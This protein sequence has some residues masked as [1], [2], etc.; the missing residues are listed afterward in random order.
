MS[1]GGARRRRLPGVEGDPFHIEALEPRLLLSGTP[2][3][4]AAGLP[5]GGR[6]YVNEVIASFATTEE[7]DSFSITV[8][9]GQRLSARLSPMDGSIVAQLE[10]VNDA[11]EVVLSSAVA[12]GPGQQVILEP[13]LLDDATTQTYTLNVRN[14]AGAGVYQLSVLL[15]GQFESELPG[16]SMN[17]T[18]EQAELLAG[19]FTPL[20]DD[21]G[22]LVV[23]GEVNG[24]ADVYAFELAAGESVTLALTSDN[25]E[26]FHST[27]FGTFSGARQAV[28][29]D[30][31]GDGRA[32]L[33]IAHSFSSGGSLRVHLNQGDG[34]F[35]A[36]TMYD[37]GNQLQGLALVDLNDDGHLDVVAVD[38]SPFYDG[39]TT[40]PVSVLLGNGDGTFGERTTY[41]TGASAAH[42]MAVADVNNDGVMDLLVTYESS[43]DGRLSVLLGNGDG[44]FATALVSNVGRGPRQIAT[45][46]VDGDGMVDVVVARQSN[47]AS[48]GGAVTTTSHQTNDDA[49]GVALL[50]GRGD[51]TFEDPVAIDT[52]HTSPTA[53]LLHDF[54]GDGRLDLVV[55]SQGQGEVPDAVGGVSLLLGGGD[56]TF[57]PPAD[58]AFG[59]TEPYALTAGDVNGDGFV[60]LIVGSEGNGSAGGGTAVLLSDGLGN[61]HQAERWFDDITGMGAA[62]GDINGDGRTDIVA[63]TASSVFSST[64]SVHLI[65]QIGV[66]ALSL[67]DDTGA[68]LTL[69][70]HEPLLHQ[71]GQLIRRFTAET[72]GTYHARIGDGHGAYALLVT[73]NAD[74]AA[75]ANDT[76]DTAQPITPGVPIIGRYDPDSSIT[77]TTTFTKVLVDGEGFRWDVWR[78]GRITSGT[79]SAFDW[80]G[81]LHGFPSLTTGL[82]E[83]G[84][85]EIV[86]GAATVSQNVTGGNG[87]V[88]VIRKIYISETDGFARYL[89]IVTNTANTAAQF[90]YTIES[91]LGT[92]GASQGT[93][94]SSGDDTFDTSD[95]WV[96]SDTGAY[97]EPA[98]T[99]VIGGPDGALQ[100]T[101]ANLDGAATTWSYLLDLAPGETKIVAHFLAQS[102][103]FD[104][105][106]DKAQRLAALP[107]EALR[108]LS[109]AER[110][111]IVNFAVTGGDE[112]H[113][114]FTAAAGDVLTITTQTPGDG[115]GEPTNSFNPAL[116]LYYDDGDTLIPVAVDQDSGDGHNA[117]LQ[118]VVPAGQGGVYRVVLTAE[119]GSGA[120]DYTLLVEGATPAAAPFTADAASVVDGGA[121]AAFPHTYRVTFSEPVL[122]TSLQASDLTVN[123]IAATS[124]TVLDARTVVFNIADADMGPGA[125]NV[126][127]AGG[128]V[129]SITGEPLQAFN[130]SFTV[131]VQPPTVV[132]QSIS[133]GEVISAEPWTYTATFSE[134]LDA[135]HLDRHDVTVTRQ[136]T[137]ET[138][139]ASTVH[140]DPAT[141]TLTAEF[142]ALAEGQYT[143]RL[144]S[145]ATSLR[146]RAGHTIDGNADTVAGDDVTVTFSVD[147]EEVAM[148][149]TFAAV[150]PAVANLARADWQGVFHVS[151]D[152]DTFTLD[153][154][155]GERLTALFTSIDVILGRIELIGPGDTVLD[156]S[157]ASTPGESLIATAAISESGVYRLRVTSIEGTGAYHITAARNATVEAEGGAV[158]GNDTAESAQNIDASIITIDGVDR[159]AVLGQL[160]G[161]G[162][163]YSFTLEDGETVSIALTSPEGRVASDD[164]LS[165]TTRL[166]LDSDD[167]W[168]LRPH[169][170]DVDGDGYDDLVISDL[171]QGGIWVLRNDGAG[172]F[173]DIER[174]DTATWAER[175]H[176]ADITGDGVVDIVATI[177]FHGF[178]LLIGN[179]DG[180]FTSPIVVHAPDVTSNVAIA[181]LVGDALPDFVYAGDD[182]IVVMENLGD[183]SFG[184]AVRLVD[185]YA[186]FV[187]VVHLDDDEHADLLF[188]GGFDSQVHT[189]LNNGMGGFHDVVAHDLGVEYRA[190]FDATPTLADFTGDDIADLVLIDQS[191]RALLVLQGQGDGTFADP[192]IH[193]VNGFIEAVQAADVDGD[194]VLDLLV[195]LYAEEASLVW[196]AGRGDG[197]FADARIIAA[198]TSDNA[199][200]TGDFNGDGLLD[201]TS[202]GYSSAGGIFVQQ[203]RRD[204]TLRL[205]DSD[206]RLL[207]QG[208]AG[209]EQFDQIITNYLATNSGTYFI[210]VT[211]DARDYSIVVAHNATFDI[212]GTGA[213]ITGQEIPADT[214]VLGHF[215]GNDDAGRP[216]LI[217]DSYNIAYLFDAYGYMW[218]I[219]GGGSIVYGSNR[220]F[221]YGGMYNWDAWYFNA[222]QSEDGDR[223]FL[224]GPSPYGSI[225]LN[226]KVYVP[227]DGGFARILEIYTNTGDTPTSHTVRIESD[228]REMLIY[229]TSSGDTVFSTADEWI[230]ATQWGDRPAVGIVTAGAGAMHPS[231]VAANNDTLRHEYTLN[232][233]PGET[234]I[235]MHFAVQDVDPAA[236]QARLMALAALQAGA[237]AGMSPAERDAVINFNID[238]SDS[239][240][241]TVTDAT[242]LAINTTPTA[243]S[244]LQMQVR[245]Y[246]LDGDNPDTPVAIA[247]DP[248]D[249]LLQYDVSG[250]ALGRYRVVVERIDGSGNYTL[251][252]DTSEP[253]TVAPASAFH[254]S[255][256]T[257]PD[258]A[259]LVAYP[260]QYTLQFSEQVLLSSVD[261]G[262]LL[263]NGI[264]AANVTVLDGN[265][266]IFDISPALAGDGLYELTIAP[267]AITSVSGRS[268][269]G[270]TAS[271]TADVTSP[272]VIESSISDGDVL[273]AAPFIYTARFSE[274]LATTNLGIED[275]ELRNVL[276]NETVAPLSFDY[277]ETTQT[278]TVA[279]DT[280]GDG[281][282]ALRLRS[283]DDAFRDLLDKPLDGAPAFPLPSGDGA[284]G[285]D[286]VVR[287]SVDSTSEAVTALAP[288]GPHGSLMFGR[289]LVRS[290]HTTGDT[291]AFTLALDAGQLLTVRVTPLDPSVQAQLTI[292]NN[293][294][295]VFT[296]AAA[297]SGQS[298]FIQSL[299]I[300]TAG[301]YTID[302]SALAGT[303]GYELQLL[304]NAV[305]EPGDHGGETNNDIASA[306]AL[307]LSSV[308]LF[309][310]FDR[311][312]AVGR[313]GFGHDFYRFSLTAGQVADIVLTAPDAI[314]LAL[315]DGE[316]NVIVFGTVGGVDTRSTIE[317][318]IAI[319]TGD[320]YLRVTGNSITQGD[321]YQLLITRGG[322]FERE[323][324]DHVG[325]APDLLLTDNGNGEQV[326]H[327]VGSVYVPPPIG[328][329]V[330]PNAAGEDFI[331]LRAMMDAVDLTGSFNISTFQS[332]GRTI[333]RLTQQ[334]TGRT[335]ETD[336]R[337][338]LYRIHAG[339]GDT[340]TATL[341][342]LT[343]NI[344]SIQLYDNQGFFLV[345]GGSGSN[346]RSIANFNDFPY[347]GDYYI[348]IRNSFGENDYELTIDRLDTPNPLFL[349]GHDVYR[350]DAHA[351]DTLDLRTV[352]PGDGPHLPQNVLDARIEL[353]NAQGDILA[354]DSNSLDG[355]NPHLIHTVDA[356]GPYFV[357][358][359]AENNTTGEYALRVARTGEPITSGDSPQVV[360]VLPNLNNAVA[361]K[362]TY[363][364][365]TFDQVIRRDTISAANLVFDN[366][367]VTV[368]GVQMIN[369]NT[370]RFELDVTGEDGVYHWT[371]T[372][373]AVSNLANQ[374][375]EVHTGQFEIDLTHPYIVGVVPSTQAAA[376]FN[377]VTFIFSEEMDEDFLRTFHY[378]VLAPDGANVSIQSVSLANG[379]EVTITFAP[380]T[381]EGIYT[382]TARSSIRD[383]AGNLLDQD[384]DGVG[385]EFEE[386]DFV[387]Q[388]N[389]QSPNLAVTNV[390]APDNA[391]FGQTIALTYTVAN[392]GSDAAIEGWQDRIY[393]STDTNRDAS[394][395]LLATVPAD[396]TFGPLAGAGN[397]NDSYTRTVF[398][399]LPV[400]TSLTSG[401]YYLIV[402]TDAGQTQ[403]E[404]VENDNARASGP[405][406]ITQLQQPDL[407]VTNAVVPPLLLAG[408]AATV[409]WTIRNTGLDTAT[410][411]WVDRIYL[412]SDN[413]LN[414][415]DTL[416]ASI[417][418]N[419]ALDPGIDVERQH[420]ITLPSNI[421]GNY[422]L[423]IVTDATDTIVEPNGENNNVIAVSIT[424]FSPAG[425]H[426]V[427]SQ[428]ATDAPLNAPPAFIDFT[429]NQPI[430]A[431]SL[432]V[433]DLAFDNPA[434]Q[435]LGVS[436]I[437][438]TTA[439]FALSVP[440]GEST[441]SYQLL[442]D[443]VTD[444]L[445]QT[446]TAFDGTL[447]IDQTGP[448]V[449]G[450]T[451]STQVVAPFSSVR[452]TFNEAMNP[453]SLAPINFRVAAPDGTPLA[454][455]AVNIISEQEIELRFT[456]WSI[457]GAYTITVLSAVTDL[458]GNP[459]NQD[460]DA[461]PGEPGDDNFTATLVLQSPNLAV[462]NIDAP[463]EGQFGQTITLTYTVTNLGP[464]AAVEGWRDRIYLSNNATLS[465]NDI[466]LHTTDATI[467]HLDGQSGNNSYSRTVTLQLP[468]DVN[469]EPG[470]YHLIVQTDALGTQPET[471]ESDNLGSVAISIIA[472]IAP[473]LQVTQVTAPA[474]AT[475]GE[476]LTLHWTLAN[477]GAGAA[478]GTWT[479][480]IYLAL[481]PN[482][483]GELIAEVTFTGTIEAGATVERQHTINLPRPLEGTYYFR[484]ETDVHNVVDEYIHENNNTGSSSAVEVVMPP[485][486]DLVVTAVTSPAS[487][488]SHSAITVTWTVLNQGPADATGVWR[489]RVL[490]SSDTQFGGDRLLGDFIFDGVIEA[491]QSIT[492]SQIVNL[493]FD[494]SGDWFI[495]VQADAENDVE[496]HHGEH[497]N[498]FVSS[499][500]VHITTLPH[501]NLQGANVTTP[502]T[503][504]ELGRSITVSWEAFNAGN[505]ATS[506]NFWWD[507]VY[508]SVDTVLDS[509]DIRL[510]EAR[511]VSALNPGESYGN[512]AAVTING[513]AEGLYYLLV[514]IDDD[515]RVEE[516]NNEG[517][518]VIVGPQ[519]QVTP[520]PP[521]DLVVTEVNAPTQAF[522]GQPVQVTYRVQNIGPGQPF[523]NWRDEVYI[524]LDEHLD[525]NDIRVGQFQRSTFD[526]LGSDPLDYTVTVNVVPPYSV[527]GEYYF[528]V[529]TDATNTVN[530]FAFEHNNSNHDSTPTLIHLTPP[531]DLELTIDNAPAVV[532]AGRTFTI[533]YTVTNF[534]ATRT[535]N[536]RWNDAVYLSSDGVFNPLEDTRLSLQPVNRPFQ[537]LHDQTVLPGGLG[538]G[539]SYSRTVTLKTDVDLEG[540]YTLFIVA[541][542]DDVVFEL[543][544]AN[545]LIALEVT[546]VAN[547]PD[548]VVSDITGDAA[549]QSGKPMTIDY[550]VT[551][552]GGGD[553][554][555]ASWTDRLYMSLNDVI[556]DD[557]D[558]LIASRQHQGALDPNDSYS[559]SF[560]FATPFDVT[561]DVRFYVRT[562]TSNV[563]YETDETNN[564]STLH[565]VAVTRITADLAA[566]VQSLATDLGRIHIAWQVENLGDTVTNAQWWNDRIIFSTN[567]ILGDDDD[568]IVANVFH[569]GALSPT[570]SYT[571]SR[572]FNPPHHL[573][574]VYHV[575][576]HV[577][578]GNAVDE[579][580]SENNNVVLA[581]TVDIAALRSNPNLVVHDVDAPLD[582]VS[583]QAFELTYIVRNIGDLFPDQGPFPPEFGNGTWVDRIYL[584]RDQVFDAHSDIYLGQVSVT[585]TDL[586]TVDDNGITYQE[587]TRTESFTVPAGLTGPFYVFVITDRNNNIVEDATMPTGES[588]NIAYDLTAMIV[589]LAPPADLIAGHVT[590]PPN[591]S[592]GGSLIVTYLLTNI[593]E[594][595]IHG[596]W[597]DR[598]FL[599]RDQVLSPDD[600]LLSSHTRTNP[601]GLEPGDSISAIASG[602]VTNVAPGDY[603]IIVRTDAFDAIPESDET[604]NLAASIQ[605]V[606]IDAPRIEIIDGEGRVYLDQVIPHRSVVTLYYRIDVE[607]GKTLR[608]DANILPFD[609]FDPFNPPDWS[610]DVSASL[611]IAHERVPGP[612]DYDYAQQ[613]WMYAFD[614]FSNT[615]PLI[616]PQT[617]EGVYLLRL[618]IQDTHL[619]GIPRYN[620]YI[621]YEIIVEE[622]PFTIVSATPQ[623]VGNVGEVTLELIL[624]NVNLCTHAELLHNGQVVRTARII[625]PLDATRALI[626]FDTTGL[627]AGEYELR[628]QD[629]HGKSASQTITIAQGVGPN[630]QGT[631]TGPAAVRERQEYV[632]YVNYG[633][634]G[635]TNGIAPLLVITNNDNNPF[636]LTRNELYA[637]D[638]A[639]NRVI[640]L[641]GISREGAAD[642]L[643]PGE[644]RSIPIFA[645]VDGGVGDY[646]LQVITADDTRPLI[647]EEI[648]DALRPDAMSDEQ[649]NA[650]RPQLQAMIGDTWG[651]YVRALA[652]TADRMAEMDLATGDVRLIV[653]T[654]VQLARFDQP[655]AMSGHLISA[656]DCLPITEGHVTLIHS[657]TGQ[658]Y[659]AAVNSRGR[660]A[661]RGVPA[662]TY[663]L[664]AEGEGH[665]RTIVEAVV[666][667]DDEP[668]SLNIQMATE[669]RITGTIHF[670][671]TGPA[672]GELIAWA[673]HR[674]RPN[675]SA[676]QY[677]LQLDGN[678]FRFIGMEAGIY[679][680]TFTRAGYL[681]VN[682]TVAVEAGQT[683]DLGDV[684]MDA[685]AGVSGFIDT[686]AL[687]NAA[688]P[689]YISAYQN[690]EHVATVLADDNGSFLFEDLVPGDYT[691]LINPVSAP[692]SETYDVSLDAGQNVT[693]VFLR[694]L[695]GATLRGQLTDTNGTPLA[696]VF[697][698]AIDANRAVYRAL[699]DAN[700]MYQFDELAHGVYQI[701]IAG[702]TSAEMISVNVDALEGDLFAADLV[703]DAAARVDGRI[704]DA[705]GN[706]LRGVAVQ[707]V[708]DGEVIATSQTEANG[709]YAFLLRESGTF[710]IVAAIDG[711]SFTPLRNVTA[712][713]GNNAMPDLVAGTG[714]IELHLEND[715]SAAAGHVVF[716]YHVVDDALLMVG[717]AMADDAGHV[718]F[719]QLVEGDYRIEVLANSTG[720][721]ASLTVHLVDGQATHEDISLVQLHTLSGVVTAPSTPQ[722]VIGAVV[723]LISR[724]DPLRHYQT[725]TDTEGNYNFAGIAQDDY[726]MVIVAD[727]LTAVVHHNVAMTGDAQLDVQL[728]A[729]TNSISGQVRDADG[730]AVVTGQVLALDAD[731]RV[732]GIGQIE[733]DGSFT[734]AGVP[735]GAIRVRFTA[736]GFRSVT[737]DVLT[738]G[739]NDH[740]V[741]GTLTTNA[742]ATGQKHGDAYIP[743]LDDVEAKLQ[744]AEAGLNKLMTTLAV[745]LGLPSWLVDV[746]FNDPEHRDDHVNAADIPDSS[747]PE[748]QSAKFEAVAAS[749][750]QLLTF[751]KFEQAHKKLET[752]ATIVKGLF[753]SE[754]AVVA[755]TAATVVITVRA[756]I[757]L[758]RSAVTAAKAA[759]GFM[760]TLKAIKAGASATAAIEVS[761][762]FHILHLLGV[763]GNGL[764]QLP[765]DIE[766]IFESESAGDAAVNTG[767]AA[768]TVGDV[769]DSAEALANLIFKGAKDLKLM[770]KLGL[771][772]GLLPPLQTIISSFRMEKTSEAIDYY[773]ELEA[774][775]AAAEAAYFAA[776]DAAN[777]KLQ[778][779]R[780]CLDQHDCPED[781]ADANGNGFGDD[782]DGDGALPPVPPDN[783]DGPDDTFKP[784]FIASLDPNDI[785]G[786]AGFGDDNFVPA[787]VDLPYMIRFENVAEATAAAQRVVITH[788]LDADLDYRTFRVDDFG[789]GDLRVELP[790]DAPFYQGRITLS[791]N[792]A[793]AVDVT[794]VVN[795]ATGLV[796]WTMQT[797]DAITGDIPL[798]PFAGFLPPNDEEHRGEGFVT[799]T[800]RPRSDAPT[801]A[802]IDAEAT[803]VFDDNEPIDTPA[804]FNTLDAVAPTSAVDP[805]PAV[806]HTAD[807]TVAVELTWSG[808][809]DDHGSALAS[810]DV[811]VSVD[812]GAFTRLLERTT[813]TSTTY[814]GQV[815]HTYAFYSIAR[816]N[817]GNTE[818]PPET[819]DAIV[820]IEPI[821][822]APTVV[823][824]SVQNGMTQR[825]Y[826]D[827]LRFVFDSA[828]NLGDLITSGAI[829]D[830]VTLTHLGVDATTD[831]AT[832]VS[833]AADQF[834]YDAAT[835][836]LTWS[837][838]SFAGTAASLSDGL[839]AITLHADLI[840]SAAGELD[841]NADATPGDDFV[842]H[843]H[844]LA[845][846]V[847]G[848]MVI[849]AADQALVDSQLGK[850]DTDPDWNPEADTDR[851]GTITTRDRATVARALG[852]QLTPPPVAE[853]SEVVTGPIV[854]TTPEP[855]DTP[856][857]TV[858]LLSPG[859]K[860]MNRPTTTLKLIYAAE[861][862][863]RY[864]EM[865]YHRPAASTP[866]LGAI[867]RNILMARTDTGDDADEGDASGRIK[868]VRSSQ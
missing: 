624:S 438:D 768:L 661:L 377:K 539:E 47:T 158:N 162:D 249:L 507:R 294:G 761:T 745:Q 534:G 421:V 422:Y 202:S 647:F 562:D 141:R 660:Y 571:A 709:D 606:T 281:D 380:R 251:A 486:P 737:S 746:Y 696:S 633:N 306:V 44:T 60:D 522:S 115:E 310:G 788:Q 750:E 669:A 200:A 187:H 392:L 663:R 199:F 297:T 280:L 550:T 703:F 841:G 145:G 483:G 192:L 798:D 818:A 613:N 657:E 362:P 33:L 371:L 424:A 525:E 122:L 602:T 670:D 69:A 592:L 747:C 491:G 184:E 263:V 394:D 313:A 836:T 565:T 96:V 596:T 262:D 441:Y 785:I 301:Q 820:T 398:V 224:F 803:I 741:A 840:A 839:Y 100:P 452:I 49:G 609:P 749:I 342:R 191:S 570:Q 639:D 502:V 161:D 17:D 594:N 409:T 700:G 793:L 168:S 333:Y 14:L 166:L 576:I 641:L 253:N 373:G 223:E 481:E 728:T 446:S 572:T 353:L 243:T 102:N 273:P 175:L 307:D 461:T 492:R 611:Y 193:E 597:T 358:I 630:V 20:M 95:W 490:L 714:S 68:V 74:L 524:S 4:L 838:D 335:S 848:D 844:V 116:A 295:I 790:G 436:L 209:G 226:R 12:D 859:G 629:H 526:F 379:N 179:G 725:T 610:R 244:N 21:A 656:D 101:Q 319:T 651:S 648:E 2:I 556:G 284:G 697:I 833:L 468:V 575:F 690:G 652:Y 595:T 464:D 829:V 508:L 137:G 789:W 772:T 338:D 108:G 850:R 599:S 635:D 619:E 390:A 378:Q 210:E 801:G 649:W 354:A 3:T 713:A 78:T 143:L 742:L 636:A 554:I 15:N 581:G 603:Y 796:T 708:V 695:P 653:I 743:A 545:N 332:N 447:V 849:D 154:E 147:A 276:T 665:A 560:T 6:A 279:F 163:V 401:T 837:L 55:A 428:P 343:G 628:I 666:I 758:V 617:E 817:A 347:A 642:V 393:L 330:E 583:G 494:V 94:T 236:A 472:P 405:V 130:A 604:N 559:G 386:D 54:D 756:L 806:I 797:V 787:D 722:G 512:S 586:I 673:Q 91:W 762:P 631:L 348:A 813:L 256:T 679:D 312:A 573:D 105:A 411:P 692:Y 493:P 510:G 546:V 56:G 258:N 434:V 402:E 440:D 707:L 626:T 266:L 489:D 177:A 426:V 66:P 196:F 487:S 607:A 81:E 110:R 26:A 861:S 269:Q 156:L 90:Q 680:I 34:T 668:L 133:E 385:G 169:V 811:Y 144:H 634:D 24:D 150:G 783:N 612:F 320:Y 252:I 735:T 233:A 802:R 124:M 520:P 234:Q 568:V 329:D 517:D 621:E 685:A 465:S 691:L 854:D 435:V 563:V 615:Q 324:N 241:F 819:P 240:V 22:H 654:M 831:P 136:D 830:A 616:L 711:A 339:P 384:R 687:N 165:F 71:D 70:E 516:Y 415:G 323:A 131:D 672:T 521:P 504:V 278:L 336:D 361:F 828:M 364:Q 219:D 119:A 30:V 104:A 566:T 164:R 532:E 126:A 58:L 19:S 356:D 557:D 84:G 578:T 479:E 399:T 416:L 1:A 121:T 842:F 417:P 235:V 800:I 671:P 57:T 114:T 208:V 810:F 331:S 217:R 763:L 433:T 776:V 113:F 752:Q 755:G 529:V 73:R 64:V 59:F 860:A 655:L 357:R 292:A 291:D 543:D 775:R 16:A 352:T 694:A 555:R 868:L 340:L 188:G 389:L 388:I 454:I 259:N 128:A 203:Q 406:L 180:T 228:L 815:G 530:E 781:D 541:D 497:N 11:G 211:G 403:P 710:D 48:G 809:D 246:H 605:S 72:A 867:A 29:E 765:G 804:I 699:T 852:A 808:G 396:G 32:D 383:G 471:S 451:P 855:E 727:D 39:V 245:L 13:T 744:K 780:E 544:N 412:S 469:L 792:D 782:D 484:V 770:D 359:V 705:Q 43:S 363:L 553:T 499:L 170:A 638:A 83:D 579:A 218:D 823:D 753:A 807:D 268:I 549:A 523:M 302:V 640:Q 425:P 863:A 598:V 506:P 176:F 37:I 80:A 328:A 231:S 50:R 123:G 410:G 229:A 853:T 97:G 791:D 5:S 688:G 87:T 120:G 779:Y 254:V 734:I 117:R 480:R 645:R 467:P 286:F 142:P 387:V 537:V 420:T 674:D 414:G 282:Y 786:P 360:S 109:G 365:F 473:D 275:I 778:A 757:P 8:D 658:Q 118:Y 153:L 450:I 239:Y 152:S 311:L 475:A 552:Q 238:D 701:G 318:F 513:V 505:G 683:V 296:D 799:Y 847:T 349:F 622:L 334:I 288:I 459:L 250:D 132:S 374:A 341:R 515:D 681:P 439:R 27:L 591:A 346:A 62:V 702:A 845:G 247:S 677:Q 400:D 88:Q 608:F 67:L 271:F 466:L 662:G 784:T 149:A 498:T 719:E 462:T 23:L 214:T 129:R 430:D 285:D 370:V 261:A 816:D 25:A 9:A 260:F 7:T 264:A 408:N 760:G 862:V 857:P 429:F 232:L 65:E 731:D 287:F 366:P 322:Q 623:K 305:V 308:T 826:V 569:S 774:E 172:G 738:I 135:T 61:F 712:N 767:L 190:G 407:Q 501:P 477:T 181:D 372:P 732:V 676:G 437:N 643:R 222:A 337:L 682:V 542:S 76:A 564:A 659:L 82:L 314:E 189:A 733:A 290:F 427:T 721:G 827:T 812:G 582:A 242:T 704:L 75:F 127:I 355:R 580:G 759:Q 518:N 185:G 382:I 174:Y 38:R 345:S 740:L 574:G 300:D 729:A 431:A 538:V 720:R 112:Q 36:A 533:R 134:D 274:P 283:G 10:L 303:G 198:S 93:L 726:D 593:G 18:V 146:D 404:T 794:I 600:V 267:G 221:D 40:R 186:V 351:G 350:I 614:G 289:T 376:P 205:F 625:E 99:Q 856:T 866:S 858:E 675:D 86:I 216:H 85:R 590:V 316:G 299:A 736:A 751:H 478:G 771:A 632:F 419:D 528:F 369:A 482:G 773:L 227:T 220:A 834:H 45:G 89:D 835:R 248:A 326:G 140:Y 442:A 585:A 197:T 293:D 456:P 589:S 213:D 148:P 667:T 304:L 157:Q 558:I 125:Y 567:D 173:G 325:I 693:D 724:N 519:L 448:Q 805:L 183:G 777:E 309:E 63:L 584:S 511:N 618:D 315:L 201:I 327:V 423:L 160:R 444:L 730:L 551:N 561:G 381:T 344:D 458:A 739:E 503:Q 824:A 851:S 92:Y 204:L 151:N 195:S 470:V 509:T 367:D 716:L 646:Q 587:Y 717:S 460:G 547:P 321:D 664:I 182:G 167:N 764:S 684:V 822:A 678:T 698:I 825:S 457:P 207:A 212:D 368:T 397:D 445:G 237:L 194:G 257:P 413:T 748:C 843:F 500:P 111:Q 432:D 375:N 41:A 230:V 715:G 644:V 650:I 178:H 103:T 107:E 35:G 795:I 689:Y 821:A 865:T 391:A 317:G 159:L 548:L 455:T 485:L 28:L 769:K 51:G 706:P 98:V 463:A 535:P 395:V 754:L 531:P 155:A 52:Q 514:R 272:T 536:T 31:N 814:D 418:F 718:H 42:H 846:D 601:G 215:D 138:F 527:S 864:Y 588:D 79:N 53:V 265:T 627:D 77:G 449:T 496:E 766:S 637:D 453:A 488:Y 832:P 723:T 255:A 495:I 46:D 686:T 206:G 298:I 476:P 443:A 171:Y 540:V 277:D 474:Q 225:E 270:F 139:I 620:S 106:V 577:D